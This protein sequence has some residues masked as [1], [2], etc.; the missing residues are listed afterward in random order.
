MVSGLTENNNYSKIDGYVY[1]FNLADV[2]NGDG[3]NKDNDVDFCEG[4]QNT[5]NITLAPSAIK[6][7]PVVYQWDEKYPTG[8]ENTD[9]EFTIQ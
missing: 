4:W 9:G 6:F 1:Y 7:N 5:L 3:A 8:D 2:F